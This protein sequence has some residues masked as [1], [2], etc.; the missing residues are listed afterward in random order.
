MKSFTSHFDLILNLVRRNFILRYKGSV[1]GVFWSI[2]LPLIQ[3]LVLVFLFRK[4][5]PLGIEDYP[6]FVFSALLPW[7]WFSS[8]LQSAGHLFLNNRDLMRRPRFTPSTLMIMDAL[9]ELLTFLISIPI[10]VVLL[11]IYGR[12]IT[13][14]LF[15]F[16]LLLLIQGVL[17]VGLG[18][19]IATLNVFYRDVAHIVSVAV[20]LLFYLTPVFY[21]PQAI[22]QEYQFLFAWN[23]MVSLI[24]S[25]RN[26]FFYGTAPEGTSLLLTSVISV[27]ACIV[28]YFLYH[29]RLPEVID[30]I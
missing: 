2:L 23:P 30:V 16:P 4:V 24:Q 27:G 13:L 10:L 19:I 11:I 6:V 7:N 5:V 3:L 8:S 18:L 12:E 17:I 1:L 15:F 9:T 21:R 14:F 20:M 29:Y 26:I 28:G 25:Y 22:A